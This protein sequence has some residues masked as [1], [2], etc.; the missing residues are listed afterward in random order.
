MEGQGVKVCSPSARPQK[1]RGNIMSNDIE[2][3]GFIETFSINNCK[4]EISF[5]VVTNFKNKEK[6]VELIS[7]NILDN[8]GKFKITIEQID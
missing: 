1:I 7:E 5:P 2:F 8:N 6:L 3:K 4:K